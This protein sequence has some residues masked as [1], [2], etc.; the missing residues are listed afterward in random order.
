MAI[1][2]KDVLFLNMGKKE[3][4]LLY[5][6]EN[7]HIITA[8]KI[9]S[10]RMKR[11]IYN[12]YP[13]NEH[14]LRGLGIKVNKKK[15]KNIYGVFIQDNTINSAF[16]LHVLG[17]KPQKYILSQDVDHEML[18][19]MFEGVRTL[20]PPWGNAPDAWR[21]KEQNPETLK[22][23]KTIRLGLFI[24]ASLSG[25]LSTLQ[26]YPVLW[27]RTVF[28]LIPFLCIYLLIRYPAY[29][30]VME[31]EKHG[32]A[33]CGVGISLLTFVT[34][35][36]SSL[37]YLRVN[38]LA[39]LR[40]I[41]VSVAVG[42]TIGAIICIFVKEIRRNPGTLVAWVLCCTLMGGFGV[43]G[44]LNTLLDFSPET[45][46]TYTV[47]QLKY[48]TGVKGGKHYDCKIMLQNGEDF[49][50]S[51]DKQTFESLS[52][53]DPVRVARREGGLGLAYMYYVED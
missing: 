41:L 38:Y 50:I 34:L 22:T 48:S 43:V 21:K 32:A 13:C 11:K 16:I 24:A 15:K 49:E 51:L 19:T 17:Q 14:T 33:E 53:G 23:M 12:L 40:Y 47:M 29:F 20:P 45:V 44:H 18:E 6:G 9:I 1:S 31:L 30:T 39:V 42:A 52:I 10:D 3:Y 46:H 27:W 5:N 37:I 25:L 7:Y 26:V 35:I 4:M 36:G 28:I 8:T 2:E